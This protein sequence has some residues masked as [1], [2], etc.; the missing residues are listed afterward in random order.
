[1][2]VALTTGYEPKTPP[3]DDKGLTFVAPVHDGAWGCV[4]HSAAWY[5]V[6]SRPE[7]GPH[8]TPQAP[9]RLWALMR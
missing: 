6:P 9:L 5:Y 8:V 1:M 7:D 2:G 3:E 4:Q